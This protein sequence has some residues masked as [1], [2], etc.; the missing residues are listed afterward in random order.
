M[1]FSTALRRSVVLCL[2]GILSGQ[3]LT[4]QTVLAAPDDPVGVVQQIDDRI[5][6]LGREEE[7]LREDILEVRRSKTDLERRG[8]VLA[9][10]LKQ[11]RTEHAE[12]DERL[13][14]LDS[15]VSEL[16]QRRESHQREIESQL[17]GAGKWVSFTHDIAPIFY[18]RC[19]ACHNARNSQ[20][21][22]NMSNYDA[23]R[24][25]GESG[26]AIVAGDAESSLLV[27]LIE[28]G[29][30]PY[31]ADALSDGEIDLVRRWIDLG[32]RLDAGADHRAP[33][34]RLM[35]RV[36]QPLPPKRY[37]VPFPITALA[38]DASGRRLASSGYHEVL[39]WLLPHDHPDAPATAI[40]ESGSD[41]KH[42]GA[43]ESV[44]LIARISNVAERVYGLDFHPDGRRLAVAS[45]TPGRLGELKVFDSRSGEMLH[46]LMVSEDVLFSAAFSP[47]GGRIATCGADGTIAVFSLD[48]S[49][50]APRMI[51]HHAD[52]VNSI[53]WSPDGKLLVS[54]SRD[55]TVKVFE[56]DTGS[57]IVN[58][59][60]S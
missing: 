28:D 6:E 22:Y 30:M 17:R 29:S 20:G 41:E 7:S 31:D 21:R 43:N 33:L 37:T 27:Q 23:I 45:G 40:Q 55:K 58:L 35:P 48:E 8:E 26:H 44:K 1:W 39:L 2:F 46:D 32:A 59:E 13:H 4:R 56:A 60:R 25:V 24:S 3:L 38:T 9:A 42:G 57:Y 14:S 34:I 50:L 15:K 11:V 52:W 53:A 18:H 36:S 5:E 49:D 51:E 47:D 16:T 54:A 10:E 12:L 19:V